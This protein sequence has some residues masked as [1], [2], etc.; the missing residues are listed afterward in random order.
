MYADRPFGTYSA[1]FLGVEPDVLAA[2]YEKNPDKIPKYICYFSVL[3]TRYTCSSQEMF[4]EDKSTLD[5]M[6][7]YTVEYVEDNILLTV[8]N[9]KYDYLANAD[10][11][12]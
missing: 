6:F 7:D 5:I 1:Y 3:D 12:S 4:S 9:Y 10:I 11:D 8:T 2:Y